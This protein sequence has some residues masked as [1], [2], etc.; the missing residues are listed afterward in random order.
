MCLLPVSDQPVPQHSNAGPV[1]GGIIATIIILCL[2][3]AGLAMYQKH[4][5][6]MEN[7]EWVWTHIITHSCQTSISLLSPSFLARTPKIFLS[8]SFSMHLNWRVHG[9]ACMHTTVITSRCISFPEAPPNTSRLLRWSLAARQKWW[10]DFSPSLTS[11]AHTSDILFQL[12]RRIELS[13]L[14]NVEITYNSPGYTLQLKQSWWKGA[15]A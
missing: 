12:F 15:Y 2:I 1:V 13:S 11:H 3:G 14:Y 5:Q 7:G 6:S 4:R 8:L 10:A 9:I